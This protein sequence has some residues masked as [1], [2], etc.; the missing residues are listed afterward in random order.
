M[1]VK[2]RLKKKIAALLIVMACIGI[3]VLAGCKK[4]EKVIEDA[5]AVDRTYKVYY[6]KADGSGV[7]GVSWSYS[8]GT[9]QALVAECLDVLS[10]EPEDNDD[11]P[12]I[13]SPVGLIDYEYLSEQRQVNLYFNDAY[14]SMDKSKEVLSRAAIVKT[15]TQFDT[16]IDYVEI[17][18]N[19]IPLTD[20]KGN[21]LR[22]MQSDF[23]DS[24]SADYKNLKASTLKLFFA[25]SD[26]QQLAEEDVLVHYLNTAA[27]SKV[28]MESLVSGPLSAALNRTFPEDTKLN[29][30]EIKN[31]VCYVDMNSRFLD[32]LDGIAYNVK[33]YS[34]VNSLC[35][36]EDIDAVQ[37]LIDGVVVSTSDEAVDIGQ[38][39]EADADVVVKDA[40]TPP[41][42]E[43]QESDE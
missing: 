8:S 15:L 16:L 29:S 34:V 40:D 32:Q 27:V 19:R 2:N 26:G 3:A 33:I 21:T 41:V 28:V 10:S 35:A 36:L 25:S 5:S 43:N 37:I 1:V 42:V 9:A 12:A 24:T 38:P 18:I 22:M 4:K 30:V 20:A 31:G 23:I 17:F 13:V 14:G 6:V 39:L 11:L 7:D